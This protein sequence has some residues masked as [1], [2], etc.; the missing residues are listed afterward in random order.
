MTQRINLRT[1]RDLKPI[2]ETAAESLRVG[3]LVVLPTETVYGLGAALASETALN[4]LFAVKGR[5]PANP[6]AIAVSGLEMLE[7]LLANLTEGQK[8]LPRRVW[9]GPVTIVLPV[10][11]DE[12][13]L[14]RLPQTAQSAVYSNGHVGFRVP[15]HPFTLDVI[16]KLDQPIV[17]TSANRSGQGESA[18]GDEI[19]NSL[20]PEVELIVEDGP[21]KNDK[22]STVVL[23]EGRNAK[24]LREGVVSESV[25]NRLLAK[26]II[27]VCTGNTCRSPMAEVLCRNLLANHFQ[28]SL[29]EVENRGYVVMSAG[30]AASGQSTAS[31]AAQQVVIARG[32]SLADHLSQPLNETHIRFADKIYA[33]TRNHREAILSFW[34]SA[35]TRLF[36]LRTDGGD[37]AD[38]YGGSIS[39][40]DD[41]ADQ[42]EDELMK[43]M[44][45]ILE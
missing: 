39:L 27:F 14:Q 37:I 30:V 45:E 41:C 6:F 42:I 18:N 33:M 36:V 34:P 44:K 35:D 17:L 9:P 21:A 13:F 22:P 10:D 1:Q 31:S 19:A 29:E 4:R 3:R 7:D 2:V 26:I 25:V 12:H 20:G 32:M 28:C 5:D 23:L 43:R 15:N 16:K 11:P 8:R 40:Y 24:I 38:P